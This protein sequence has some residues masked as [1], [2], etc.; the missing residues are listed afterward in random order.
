MLRAHPSL[1]GTRPALLRFFLFQ[2]HGPNC[3][4]WH[5]HVAEM[6]PHP[7]AVRGI[8]SLNVPRRRALV[9]GHEAMTIGIERLR[10]PDDARLDRMLLSASV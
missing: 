8:L 1:C 5:F 3:P 2:L 9:A 6:V 4:R 10:E 7:P